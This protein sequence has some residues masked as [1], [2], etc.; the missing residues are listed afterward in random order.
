MSQRAAII[1]AI[2]VALMLSWHTARLTSC[3]SEDVI[4]VNFRIG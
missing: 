1:A 3:L 2:L 4:C